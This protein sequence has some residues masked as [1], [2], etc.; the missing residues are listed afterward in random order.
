MTYPVLPY[1]PIQAGYGIQPGDGTQRIALDGGS[2]RYRAG[3]GGASHMVTATYALFGEEYD[4]FMGFM[5]TIERSGGGPFYADLVIDGS[6]KLRYV[7]HFIPNSARASMSGDIFTVSVTLEVDRRP[8]YEDP[9][10]DFWAQFLKFIEIYGSIRAAREA[11]NLLEK[12]VNKDWPN[13]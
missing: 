3:V 11:F 9:D 7:A 8:E 4:A 5:R 2:G 10:T 12:I 6:Y 13:A 1:Q